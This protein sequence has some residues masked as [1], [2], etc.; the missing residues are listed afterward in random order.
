MHDKNRF[1]GAHRIV[2]NCYRASVRLFVTFRYT[3]SPHGSPVI[4][5]L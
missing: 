4:L 3:S 5:V 2:S 1:K